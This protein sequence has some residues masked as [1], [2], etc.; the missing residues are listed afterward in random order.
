MGCAVYSVADGPT[1][2]MAGR[3]GD[4]AARCG[5]SEARTRIACAPASRSCPCGNGASCSCLCVGTEA[6]DLHPLP[7]TCCRPATTRHV[8]IYVQLI[9]I[10]IHEPRSQRLGHHPVEGQ[11][12]PSRGHLVPAA[13]TQKCL[14]CIFLWGRR[15]LRAGTLSQAKAGSS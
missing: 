5:H 1:C 12:G 8:H 2:C 11:R 13:L 10:C 9:T 4:G 6:S 7:H 15:A 14:V 3:A